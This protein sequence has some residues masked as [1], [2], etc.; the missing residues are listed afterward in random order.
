MYVS[1]TPTGVVPLVY[2]QSCTPSESE[3]STHLAL[4]WSKELWETDDKTPVDAE[5]ALIRTGA[6]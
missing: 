1:A 6:V 4:N 5:D 3:S 2:P